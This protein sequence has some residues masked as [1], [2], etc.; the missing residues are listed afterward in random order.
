VHVFSEDANG[1]DKKSASRTYFLSR[2]LHDDH[3]TLPP[4]DEASVDVLSLFALPLLRRCFRVAIL[5]TDF[6]RSGI[7]SSKHGWA[8]SARNLHS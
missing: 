8:S 2:F 1:D 4:G 5:I 3:R 7:S 6:Q